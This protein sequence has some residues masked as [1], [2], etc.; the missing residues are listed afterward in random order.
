MLARSL[1]ALAAAAVVAGSVAI[2]ASAGA[3]PGPATGS[4]TIVHGV[5]GLV[6][7]VYL[8]GKLALQ[9]FQP[10]RTA[11]PVQLP[12]GVHAVAVRKAGAGQA[13]T[14]LLAAQ[15]TV[16]PGATISAVVHLTAA[17]A[18]ALTVFNDDL[19]QVAA[20]Q[21]RAV[22]RH[23]AAA[24]PVD[25]HFNNQTVADNLANPKETEKQVAPA[26]YSVSVTGAN[27]AALTTPQNVPLPEG[28]ATFMYLVGS[29]QTKSL[30]WIAKAVPNLATSPKQVQTG[31]SGLAAPHDGASSVPWLAI[32]G[33]VT[34]LGL[35]LVAWRLP[36][37]RPAR[38]D[39]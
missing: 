39:V 35:A 17:G 26:T 25:V 31:D 4:V 16:A 38:H 12:A 33:I 19:S 28:S 32:M 1:R 34:A 2:G 23:V 13:T 29:A 15:I 21:A 36:G 6:A 3:A 27:G 5:R 14:P 18:P 11:G 7:D 8:D 37:R 9:T 22:V 24:P 20:G 30:G 10:E